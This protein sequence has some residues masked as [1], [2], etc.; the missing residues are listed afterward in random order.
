MTLRRVEDAERFELPVSAVIAGA[1]LSS[2]GRSPSANV[3]QS[4]GQLLS[5]ERCYANYGIDPASIVAIEAHGTST[6]VGD[7]TELVTLRSFF[8]AKQADPIPIHS[9][10]GLLG[11]AGWAAG[12]AS[13]IAVCEYLR[14]GLFPHRPR[15]ASRQTR[16]SIQAERS[17][18]RQNRSRC[19]RARHELPSMDLASA[20]PMRTW[21]SSRYDAHRSKSKPVKPSFPEIVGD[22][23]ELVFVAYHA[24]R[25]RGSASF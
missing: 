20:E 18:F 23:G 1:G 11:H 7:A 9:L 3:P 2:D 4:K 16:Y 6:P 12:T 14:N 15:F 5:L 21:C 25:P 24:E 13:V 10:K 22:E 19:R 8:A 17:R